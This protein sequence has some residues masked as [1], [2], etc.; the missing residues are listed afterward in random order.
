MCNKNKAEEDMWFWR[1][2]T[3]GI[4]S[5][6]AAYEKNIAAEELMEDSIANKAFKQLWN[7]KTP[8]WVKAIV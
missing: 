4:Y 5:T 2:S 8:K 1:H 6:K 7:N 3:S